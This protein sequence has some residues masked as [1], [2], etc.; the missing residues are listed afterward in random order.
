MWLAY[1]S[2]LPNKPSFWTGST[3]ANIWVFAL[4]LFV[5]SSA[6]IILNR[7]KVWPWDDGILTSSVIFI[8]IG[9]F[10]DM[11]YHFSKLP[12]LILGSLALLPGH[13]ASS[14]DASFPRLSLCFYIAH[15]HVRWSPCPPHIYTCMHRHTYTCAWKYAHTH[16]HA[17]TYTCSH[18]H[19]HTQAHIKYILI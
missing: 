6:I 4:K 11:K 9:P 15:M 18:A 3:L 1:S 7:A 12:V 8:E 5:C 17:H 2:A 14:C 13:A 16:K 10:E 19:I